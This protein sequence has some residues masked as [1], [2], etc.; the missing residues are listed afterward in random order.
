MLPRLPLPCPAL[1]GSFRAR[2][3]PPALPRFVLSH[4]AAHP[5]VW[6]W[7]VKDGP[8]QGKSF[9][10]PT[11]PIPAEGYHP[12]LQTSSS[13]PTRPTGAAAVSSHPSPARP[14]DPEIGKLRVELLALKEKFYKYI[15][16]H[17]ACCQRSDSSSTTSEEVSDS[18]S[19]PAPP[20]PPEPPYQLLTQRPDGIT[21]PDPNPPTWLTTVLSRLDLP[22]QFAGALY[23]PDPSLSELPP[24]GR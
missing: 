23:T 17:E 21:V 15:A 19:H 7:T 24:V 4:F 18:V 1:G 10:V 22:P 12:L 6:T 9:Q 11:I 16:S 8:N 14:I 2:F 13:P 5:P 3:A 20:A